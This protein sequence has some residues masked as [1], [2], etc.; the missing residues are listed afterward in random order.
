MAAMESADPSTVCHH[1]EVVP[2]VAKQWMNPIDLMT[3]M[4][5]KPQQSVSKQD[6][7][8]HIV[9]VIIGLK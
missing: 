4:P 5:K 9:I 3:D 8:L 1:V 6:S 7:H 2:N